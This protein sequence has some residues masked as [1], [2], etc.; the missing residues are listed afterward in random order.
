MVL[1]LLLVFRR[2]VKSVAFR[3]GLILW[4]GCCEVHMMEWMG[5]STMVLDERDFCSG[6]TFSCS[7]DYFNA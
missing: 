1:D 5:A 3:K 7:K 2:N 4:S 6:L